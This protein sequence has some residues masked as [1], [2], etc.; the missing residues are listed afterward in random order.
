[1]LGA[2]D[3]QT[4][5]LQRVKYVGECWEWTK[6][7]HWKGYG[8]FRREYRNYR[9][10]REAYGAFIGPIPGGLLVCHTCDNPACCNPE[11][12]YLG[13]NSDNISEA[14]EKGRH[15]GSRE[16]TYNVIR[17]PN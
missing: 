11:H 3:R 9:A 15:Q 7:K 1:M 13:N 6:S 14:V 4:F 5:I 16:T 17:Y 8:V 12:L 2:K 10:H